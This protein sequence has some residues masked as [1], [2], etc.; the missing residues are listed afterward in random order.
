MCGCVGV[1]ALFC[2]RLS[3]LKGKIADFKPAQNKSKFCK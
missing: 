1:G 3:L 2:V